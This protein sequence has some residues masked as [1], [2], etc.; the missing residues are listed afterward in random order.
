M[1]NRQDL[2]ANEEAVRVRDETLFAWCIYV[3]EPLTD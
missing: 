3:I 2:S 1:K